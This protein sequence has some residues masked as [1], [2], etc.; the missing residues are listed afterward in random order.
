MT[1]ARSAPLVYR[2]RRP[3][4]QTSKASAPGTNQKWRETNENL[5]ELLYLKMQ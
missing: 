3:C 5:R 2:D 4:L 1:M